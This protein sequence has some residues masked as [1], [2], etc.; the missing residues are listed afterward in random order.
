MSRAAVKFFLWVI[1]SP[2]ICFMFTF[3]YFLLSSVH[4]FTSPVQVRNAFYCKTLCRNLPRVFLDVL[5]SSRGSS[6]LCLFFLCVFQFHPHCALYLRQQHSLLLRN[7]QPWR[8]QWDGG[9]GQ[10][11]TRE[12]MLCGDGGDPGGLSCLRMDVSDGV[13]VA[14]GPPH[15]QLAGFGG[16]WL[17]CLKLGKLQR[18]LGAAGEMRHSV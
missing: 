13:A 15:L 7:P 5:C 11:I 3:L 8:W 1:L 6:A 17:P 12:L 10:A 16:L 14:M 4:L 9:A 2:Y 18:A